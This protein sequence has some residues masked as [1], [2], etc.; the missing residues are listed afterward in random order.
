MTAPL[1][2]CGCGHTI[3][4]HSYENDRQWEKRKASGL[5]RAKCKKNLPALPSERPR[6]SLATSTA[7]YGRGGGVAVPKEVPVVDEKYRSWVREMPCLVPGCNFA[8]EFHH[9]NMKAHGGTSA[10]CSDY[11][12]LPVCRWHHTLGGFEGLPGSYHGSAK[13]TGWRFWAVY[14]VDVEATIHNLNRL[15]LE[16]GHHFKEGQ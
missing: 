10:L 14:G 3:E 7:N 15:W 9:Q 6:P 11:R 13:L 2:K 8:S 4:R 12:G 1:C 5:F 16:Q